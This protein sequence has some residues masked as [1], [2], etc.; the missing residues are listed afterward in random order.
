MSALPDLTTLRFVTRAD[1]HKAGVLTGFLERAPSGEVTFR[2]GEGYT[3]NLSPRPR[4]SQIA[5]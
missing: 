4:R 2:Y 3:G 1:V 5:L